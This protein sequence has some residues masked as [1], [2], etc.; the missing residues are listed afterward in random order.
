MRKDAI[1]SRDHILLWIYQSLETLRVWLRPGKLKKASQLGLE[2]L[3]PY[4]Y[5]GWDHL[6]TAENSESILIFAATVGELRAAGP[7]ISKVLEK[8]PN[9]EL[10]L[11]PGKKEYLPLYAEL[12]PEAV[13]LSPGCDDYRLVNV[14]FQAFGIKL[15]ILIEGPSLMGRFP[16]WLGLAFP[17]VCLKKRVQTVVVNACIYQSEKQGYLE[18]L[19]TKAFAPLHKQS[20]D[21][22]YVAD[23]SFAANLINVGVPESQIDV[24]GDIKFDSVLS[25]E[26]QPV[27]SEFGHFIEAFQMSARPLIVAGSV[28]A[29]DEI[30]AIIR[31]WLE[32]RKKFPNTKLVLAPRYIHEGSLMSSLIQSVTKFDLRYSLRSRGVIDIEAVDVIIL[33]T[34]GE[35][36]RLYSVA[37]LVYAGRNHGVLEPMRFSKPV[38]VGPKE[39]W[40]PEYSTSYSLYCAMSKANALIN[41]S[42]YDDVG[43]NMLKILEDEKYRQNIVDSAGKILIKNSGASENIVRRI[44]RY[45]DL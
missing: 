23:E 2:H 15:F 40:N 39:Y 26:L 16:V 28:K 33:D 18:R 9:R 5:R 41:C 20:I 30:E 17:V 42:T 14:L 35:L 6:K 21:N 45:A 27:S 24:V 31:G 7:L 12:Y 10:I 3:K 29:T 11:L 8:W 13:I 25:Q 36:P 22:W 38:I 4:I 32:V 19:R 43:P 44:T 1:S 37:N 34:F